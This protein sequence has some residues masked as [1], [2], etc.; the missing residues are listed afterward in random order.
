MMHCL[1]N[2]SR[3]TEGR[4]ELEETAVVRQAGG[5]LDR[6]LS[7][8]AG[9]S[10]E[11]IGSYLEEGR[12]CSAELHG[13]HGKAAQEGDTVAPGVDE[14]IDRFAEVI[15]DRRVLLATQRVLTELLARDETREAKETV[16]VNARV[17]LS[18]YMIDRKYTAH[19]TL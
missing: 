17:F 10:P 18:A 19:R 13:L 14:E 11:A 16:K 7:E 1:A 15:A 3:S 12:G 2:V 8:T 4:S 5:I 9:M 6:F